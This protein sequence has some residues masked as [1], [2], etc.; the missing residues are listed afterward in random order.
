MATWCKEL[1]HSKRPWYWERLKAGR[2]GDDRGWDGWMASL[3]R[4]T[5]VWTRSGSWWWTGRPDVLQSMESQRVRHDWVTELN[6]WHL[7]PTMGFPGGASGKEPAYQC[8]RYNRHKFDPL[9]EGTAIHSIFLLENP[10]GR[11]VWKATI[12]RVTKSQTKLK[13]FKPTPYYIFFI[14]FIVSLFPAPAPSLRN[15]S[16]IKA[17]NF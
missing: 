3:T 1:T 2:E 8:K 5:W 10:M 12:Y 16:F 6:W 13:W 11:G 4:Y 7:S 15:G 17:D 9:E 14:T